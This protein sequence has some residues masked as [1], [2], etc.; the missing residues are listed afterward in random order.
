[1]F[2]DFDFSDKF[3]YKQV[4]NNKNTYINLSAEY[5]AMLYKFFDCVLIPINLTIVHP[6]DRI[7]VKKRSDIIPITQSVNHFI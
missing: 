3:K 5:L 1:M 6:I 7:K 4:Q 2:L